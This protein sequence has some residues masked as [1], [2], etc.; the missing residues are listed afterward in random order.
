MDDLKLFLRSFHTAMIEQLWYNINLF[1]GAVNGAIVLNTQ[2][3]SKMAGGV[4]QWSFF[5]RPT[6]LVTQAT[7]TG[8]RPLDLKKII[9][10][11]AN[12]IRIKWTTEAL[13]LSKYVWNWIGRDPN[14]AGVIFGR[15]LADE[16]LAAYILR[17]FT[18]IK[19]TVGHNLSTCLDVTG[20]TDPNAYQVNLTNMLYA[21]DMLGDAA[22][23]L[24]AWI[25]P[26]A[27]KTEMVVDNIKNA[28]ALFNIGTVN[29]SRDVEGR[30]F[31]TSDDP[32]LRDYVDVG[33]TQRLSWW[34]FGL[35]AEAIV[36]E[37]IDD[38][39]YVYDEKGGYENILRT[40]NANWSSK[41]AVKGYK[42]DETQLQD[43][44]DG[45]GKFAS[46]SLAALNAPENWAMYVDSHKFAAGVAIR[47]LSHRPAYATPHMYDRNPLATVPA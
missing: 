29:I 30:T 36:I 41:I 2:R 42:F 34:V 10:G 13:D 27:A 33:G 12:A 39:D 24:R 22:G 28:T 18:I 38:Y 31:I 17:A 11:M 9:N 44:D 25:M 37:D 1:N 15:A 3:K 20:E 14:M 8:M 40:Y 32:S 16:T 46:A 43:S 45:N 23:Q 47:A 7:P 26:S 5:R 4:E 19:A 6:G 35:V 21:S